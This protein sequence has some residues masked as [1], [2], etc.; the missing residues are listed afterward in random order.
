[1][2]DLLKDEPLV[3]PDLKCSATDVAGAFLAALVEDLSMSF[4]LT[5]PE[6][7][8]S[9]IYILDEP[10]YAINTK[11]AIKML[12]AE[13]PIYYLKRNVFGGTILTDF[14]KFIK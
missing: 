4:G 11:N 3:A 8:K 13:T 7:T 14:D 10:F 2:E 5:T 6:W 9:S 1:V 12:L